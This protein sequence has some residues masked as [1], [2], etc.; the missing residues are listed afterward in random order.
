MDNKMKTIDFPAAGFEFII[1]FIHFL[2]K[3]NILLPRLCLNVRN[4]LNVYGLWYLINEYVF[5]II[6]KQ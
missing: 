3:F 1:F 4:N 2:P 5:N 6:A